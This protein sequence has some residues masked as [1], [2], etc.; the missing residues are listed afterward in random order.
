MELLRKRKSSAHF[1]ESRQSGSPYKR[2]RLS[3]GPHNSEGSYTNADAASASTVFEAHQKVDDYEESNVKAHLNRP[4]FLLDLFC[5][6]AGV[7]AAFRSLG[8]DALGIDHMV[9]KRRVKGPVAKVDLD[10]KDGQR[11]ILNWIRESKVDACMLAPPCGTSS[12][13]REIPLPRS[14]NLRGGRQPTPLRSNTWPNGLPQLRGVA[15][16]KVQ[17]A[18][19]LY[20]FTRDVIDACIEANIPFIC[21]NPKRSLMW[22][23][24][25]FRDL[26]HTCRSQFV[27]ARMYGS[28]RR[29]STGL[30]MNFE[31][32]NLKSECDGLH[33]HLPWGLVTSADGASKQFSTSLETE[34][35]HLFCKQLAVAFAERLQKLGKPLHTSSHHDDQIQKLGAGTQPRGARS[36]ILLGEFKF[37]ILVSSEGV[38]VPQSITDDVHAP[39]QGIPVHAKLISSRTLVQMGSDGEKK[40]F[41]QSMFGV[42]SSPWEFFQKTLAVEHPLDTPQ[43]VE[44]SNLRAMLFIR[45]HSPAEVAL[46]RTA[47]LKKFTLRAAELTE[48]EH[49]L[50]ASLDPDVRSV[51]Q[52]KRLLLFKEMAE[53]A[54]VGD[55]NLFQ[56]L[57]GG[58]PLTGHMPESKQFPAKLKPAL[59]SVQQLRESA[60]WAKKMI[61]SSCRRI[62]SD[63]EVATA[64]YEETMQQL[65][66]GWVRGPFTE[67]QLDDKYSGCWVPSKRFGVR[68][69]QKIRA[70]DDFSEFLI[71]ASVST[72]EKLQLFGMDEVVNT[73]R[74]FLGVD[75]LQVNDDLSFVEADQ[76][77]C[78]RGPWTAIKGRALDLKAAYKQLARS[79]A[80]SWASILAVWNEQKQRVE[81]FESVALPFGSVCAVMAFNR[82]A[83]ALRL[84]M[85]QLF[86]LVN[87]NFFDD[88][89]QLETPSLCESSWRTAELV[90]QLLGWK[91]SMSDDKRLPFED[92]FNMLGA[93]VDLAD[94]RNGQVRVKNKDSRIV[95][96]GDLVK[97]ICAKQLVPQSVIETLK[98]RLLYAAGH[99]FGRCTQLAVQLVSRLARRGP[100]VVV[101]DDFKHV[102]QNA[103]SCLE[104]AK[105]REIAA[106]SGRPPLVIFTDGACEENGE[107]VT[108]GA[109]FYDPED[110]LSMMFGDQVPSEWVTK[111]KE[112]GRKQLICQ[113]EIFPILVSKA[114][115]ADRITGR[116][117]LWFVD[118]NSAL[119][120]VIRSFSAVLENYELLTLNA[121]LDVR[122]Q[123]L[124]WYTRVPSKSNLSDSPSRMCFE[125]LAAYGFVRCEPLYKSLTSN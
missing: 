122:L 108:H 72:S 63:K 7:A 83:R 44:R 48:Q 26:H 119:A 6:T 97:D 55:E 39:F 79:P 121:S 117:V 45:D 111:W 4:L 65:Q 109:T 78:A 96:I 90:M 94:S 69:G 14:S 102:L 35:P 87:T 85:S 5:G 9:D 67:E 10:K 92:Q 40:S 98:G 11:T 105:P 114:T 70:V 62:S 75:F 46:F 47:Q 73:A 17:A 16:I 30:L 2:T 81:F 106:W 60:V 54:Q 110:G 8:G 107:Q 84:I 66:D 52:G 76:R 74:T 91:V 88:F 12:R 19:R 53:Q 13:A 104:R 112:Q 118:N 124:N 113:A 95:D 33:Q 24:T 116:A 23:T 18:N 61:Q 38:E 86:M 120:A 59:I 99:T 57:V 27:H 49:K 3:A 77:M 25:P 36:P 101:D 125:E 58:F 82:M 68:Q 42:Y 28:R 100:M 51:L 43:L 20:Q 71:N 64:V 37:K 80:D 123:C 89:C 56:E 50:K 29:K 32:N 21:E 22:L 31:A 103:F 115:W 1:G 41:Q 15:K 34:Y 93:V